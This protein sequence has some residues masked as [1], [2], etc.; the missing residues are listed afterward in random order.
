MTNELECRECQEL[1]KRDVEHT[2]MHVARRDGTPC[3]GVAYVIGP[4][5]ERGPHAPGSEVS[6]WAD[7]IIEMIEEDIRTGRVPASVATFSELHDW[8]DANDYLTQAEIPWGSDELADG[9]AEQRLVNIVSTEITRRLMRRTA[10]TFEVLEINLFTIAE[11]LRVDYGIRAFVD[12][13]G[14]NT[15]T[16]YLGEPDDDMRYII[17]MGPGY[18]EDSSHRTARAHLQEFGI[19]PD[20][21][22]EGLTDRCP[23]VTGI[24]NEDE[25][26]TV[27][28]DMYRRIVGQPTVDPGTVCRYCATSHTDNEGN[29]CVCGM[30][31]FYAAHHAVPDGLAIVVFSCSARCGDVIDGLRDSNGVLTVEAVDTERR[32]RAKA[33]GPNGSPVGSSHLAALASLVRFAASALSNVERYW[34]EHDLPG[35]FSTPGSG[36]PFAVSLEEQTAALWGWVESLESVPTVIDST[37][38]VA[39]VGMRLWHDGKVRTVIDKS[40]TDTSAML[41]LRAGQEVTPIPGGHDSPVFVVVDPPRS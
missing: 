34:D 26:V 30:K 24:K 6:R 8:V 31:G 15:A 9:P 28:A 4:W 39:Q 37:M 38:A 7:A 17:S 19:G 36:F 41:T 18:F 40:M 14:G 13:T 5:S 1:F 22:A 16:V 33:Y 32:R 35:D 23:S 12:H 25:A 2:A 27:A 20:G 21:L 10:T 3:D 11:R 29:P